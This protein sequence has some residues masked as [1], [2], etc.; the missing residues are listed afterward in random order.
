MNGRVIGHYRVLEKIGEGG[1]G[2]VFRAH[3]ERLGRDVALKVVRQSSRANPDHQRRFEQEARAAAALNHPNIVAI[4]DVGFEDDCPYIV[5]ELLEGETLRARLA[6]GP[7]PV[8][9]ACDY[10]LQIV[11][12][13]VAAHERHIIHRDLKPENLFLT[14]D[15]HVK[16][17]DFGVAKLQAP[18]DSSES[19]ESMA[20]VTKAGTLVGTVAYMSPEQLRGKTVDHRTDLFSLGAI[21]YEM[22]TGSRAFKGETE[23]D[24]MTSVLREEPPLSEFEKSSVPLTLRDIVWHCLEKEPDSRFQSAKDLAFGLETLSRSNARFPLPRLKRRYAQSA[25]RVLGAVA[26]GAALVLAI[27][28]LHPNAPPKYQRLTFERGTVYSARFAP[29]GQSIIYAAAWNA[30]PLQLFSTVGHSLLAEP[31]AFKDANLL[32]ISRSNELALL[33][34][35]AHLAHLE[36]EG[37]MLARAPLAG[38]SPRQVLADVQWADWDPNG[39]LAVVHQVGGQNRLEYPTGHVL[40]QSSGWISHIRFSPDGQKIAFMDHPALWDD[41]GS[42]DVTDLVGHIRVLSSGWQSEDGLDWRPDGKEIWFAAVAKG[43]D[44]NLFGVDLGGKLRTVLALPGELTLLDIGSDGRVLVSLNAVRMA[45]KFETRDGKS[46]DLSWHDWNIAH[47]ISADGENVLFEDSS[48]AAGPKY[49]VA[50]RKVNGELPVRLGEGS[51]GGLS[52]DGKWA[53][54]ILPGTPNIT[55]LPVG[56]GQARTIRVIG[57]EKILNGPARFLPDGKHVT[58]NGNEPGHAVR[59]YIVDLDSG[60]AKPVTPEGTPGLILSP[61]QR[62]VLAANGRPRPIYSV[63]DGSVRKIPGFD[64]N[65]LLVRWSDDGRALY[66]YNTRN[67]PSEVYKIDPDTGKKAVVHTL[68]AEPSPGVVYIAP[69]VLNGDAS[70]FLYS[71]YQVSSTL[72]VISGLQ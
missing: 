37:G 3:D 5:S 24:T 7:I 17:L 26:V 68:F 11:R 18:D 54:S 10:S 33:I 19:I 39:E 56:P 47:D 6:R 34:G 13:L 71:F 59:C 50:M 31:L 40:Y 63:T 64:P 8:A 29:D 25:L 36:P 49:S 70:R 4:Y 48:E 38:G 15:G 67:I 21:L 35:G 69:L 72:Y 53:I 57:V 23:V 66:G 65:I 16:I 62:Y 45:L 60:K 41:R 32:A 43:N 42:V 1:M 12:G 27:T 14:R 30:N 44:R 55:L 2:E 9:Q 52:P 61:D 28:Y 22:L 58:V 51:A 46:L 20:T